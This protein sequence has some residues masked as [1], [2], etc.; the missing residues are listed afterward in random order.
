MIKE[1]KIDLT[2][3]LYKK[4]FKNYLAYLIVQI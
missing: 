3:L 2:T 4:S 1:K